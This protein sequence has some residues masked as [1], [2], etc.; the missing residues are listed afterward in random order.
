MEVVFDDK[1]NCVVLTEVAAIRRKNEYREPQI[2]N[3]RGMGTIK[4]PASLLCTMKSGVEIRLQFKS[5]EA[6]H[7]E[8]DCIAEKMESLEVE[9]SPNRSSRSANVE[10][11]I[12]D[13]MENLEAEIPSNRPSRSSNVEEDTP[14]IQ[15]T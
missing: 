12:V 10:D 4:Q 1:G 11:Y 13:K 9:I 15:Y 7:W 14:P 5:D 2:R 8:A 3:G 6:M